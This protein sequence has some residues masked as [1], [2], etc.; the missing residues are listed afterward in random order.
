LTGFGYFGRLA[1]GSHLLL[2]AVDIRRNFSQTGTRIGNKDFSSLDV[3][4]VDAATGKSEKLETGNV[5]TE[6]WGADSEGR[7]RLRIDEYP[8][9]KSQKVFARIGSSSE[10]QLVY[11]SGVVSDESRKLHFG[12][13]AATSD[14]AYV[15]TRNGGDKQAIYEFNLASKTLGRLIFQHPEVDVDQVLYS[16]NMLTPVGVGYTV[17]Y[18]SESYFDRGYAQ[19]Q[20]DLVATF[21]GEHVEILSASSDRKK[22]VARVE[23]PQNPTGAYYFADMNVPAISK[24]GDRYSGIAAAQIGRVRSF[25][26]KARDGLQIPAYLILPP[27]SPEKKLA[28]RRDAA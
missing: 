2:T 8:Q 18:D 6:S 16:D 13:M 20:A 4:K 24:L 28:A 19:I 26:Y 1:G 5:N 10:W 3:Y 15:K 9:R 7:V 23:G 14:T 17:D 27:G 25:S 21:A 11:D 22:F 12:G